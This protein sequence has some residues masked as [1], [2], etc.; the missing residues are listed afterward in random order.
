MT[1]NRRLPLLTSLRRK[2]W[3][4]KLFQGCPRWQ[5]AT[6]KVVIV[7]DLKLRTFAE[8]DYLF[9]IFASNGLVQF[10]VT[11]TGTTLTRWL[12]SVQRRSVGAAEK[13]ERRMKAQGYSLPAPPTPEL[14]V[15]Y[16]AAA[17]H[18]GNQRRPDG[19]GFS[20]GEFHWREWPLDNVVI[21]GQP[22]GPGR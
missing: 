3:A 13:Y 16:D 12:A 5:A 1:K 19:R 20:G 8:L 14:R 22:G 7:G 21:V 11:A 4:P 17:R 10:C 15:V 2:T 9:A 6:T 18:E